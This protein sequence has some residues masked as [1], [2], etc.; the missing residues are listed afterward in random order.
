MK[1]QLGHSTISSCSFQMLR[2][3]V[4]LESSLSPMFQLDTSFRQ[5]ADGLWFSLLDQSLLALYKVM[6]QPKTP[7]LLFFITTLYPPDFNMIT[8][9]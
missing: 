2:K 4:E 3:N 9:N 6:V 7:L 5:A 1:M 8:D